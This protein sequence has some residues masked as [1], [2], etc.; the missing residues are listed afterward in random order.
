LPTSNTF[1]SMGPDHLWYSLELNVTEDIDLPFS[2]VILKEAA[3]A[4]HCW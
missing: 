1:V 2:S 4:Q 3:V